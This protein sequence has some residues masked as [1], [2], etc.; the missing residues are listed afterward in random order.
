MKICIAQIRHRISKFEETLNEFKKVCEY[1][2]QNNVDILLLPFMFFVYSEYKNLL[3][4]PEILK[5]NLDCLDFIKNQVDSRICVVFGHYDFYDGRLVD[6][7]SVVNN[8]E[9][10]LTTR[11]INIP[12]L[13]EYKGQSITVL[14]F[15]DELL[16]RGFNYDFS[17]CFE[18]IQYLLIPSKSYFTKEKNNLR[19]SF[20]ERLVIENN[21]EVAYANLCGVYDSIVFDGLSFFINK[22]GK[23]V[24]AKEFEEDILLNE[25]FHDLELDSH[26]LILDKVILALVNALREYVY[27]TGFDKVHLGISGGIDS[28]L[29]AYIACVA[30]GSDKVVG[31]SMPSKFSSS[32]SV[33]DAEELARELKF[34]LLDMP[35]EIVFS[36]TLKFFNGYFNTNGITE[37]NLQA[38][39]RGLFLMSYSNANMSLLLN[40]GNKSE[41]A[42]GYYTLYGDSCG[43]ITLIG[44][45][46]KC[47]VYELAKHINIRE[48]RDVI[49]TNII[50]KE[51]SAELKPGQK[52]TDSLPIYEVLDDILIRYLIKNE[53]LDLLY[54]AFGK[55]LVT[56]VLSLYS[57]SEYKRRQG[58]MI[59]KISRNAFGHDILLPVSKVG[60]TIDE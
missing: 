29:V 51:P 53:P 34:K 17:A 43:G 32:E 44:D 21:I 20:F 18:N 14:N 12:I 42:V 48:G 52:D 30:L 57:G 55:E 59:V 31:I 15:E 19:L 4:R 45:L 6:C 27:L 11:E 60:L 25:G 28:A 23:L 35:I 22:H 40:T 56:K 3:H 2:L 8:H 46:F 58:P 5:K 54:N 13:F 37:E 36:T 47:D 16:F 50:L 26:S 49:P 39:L 41:I 33:S 10:I 38:R 1:A 7:I 24:Q 9:F